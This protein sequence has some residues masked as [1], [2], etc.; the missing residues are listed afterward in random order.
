MS[1]ILRL[2]SVSGRR[3]RSTT[4]LVKLLA[5]FW[6]FSSAGLSRPT[7][8]SCG[9]S[10]RPSA[11]LQGDVR[12]EFDLA[13]RPDLRA[14]CLLAPSQHLCT[15]VS[16]GTA[17]AELCTYSGLG[18]LMAII[19]AAVDLRLL[20]LKSLASLHNL[21]A[22]SV[23]AAPARR[24]RCQM[25]SWG[26]VALQERRWPAPSLPAR[27]GGRW[28][29][30]SAGWQ[31]GLLLHWGPPACALVRARIRL[32]KRHRQHCI[33]NCT[34][35]GLLLSQGPPACALVGAHIRCGKQCKQVGCTACLQNVS[36]QSRSLQMLEHANVL[37]PQP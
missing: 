31:K 36:W 29:D 26:G 12:V 2:S 30:L 13:P 37:S 21:A 9:I 4:P 8:G 1:W 6:A 3:V 33:A 14:C 24:S 5:S 32:G 15:A 22:D 34:L 7:S 19:H 28:A 11:V 20:C 10:M 27:R 23:E 35:P 17:L 16:G 18:R 25:G